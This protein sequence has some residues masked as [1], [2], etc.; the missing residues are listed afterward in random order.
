MINFFYNKPLLRLVEFLLF[1]CL[2][3]AG[4]LYLNASFSKL[5]T[6]GLLDAI[7][8][9][10]FIVAGFLF[11]LISEVADSYYFRALSSLVTLVGMF[12][13][14]YFIFTI[15][16]PHLDPGFMS[17]SLIAF[18][19]GMAF[20]LAF[21]IIVLGRLVAEKIRTSLVARI[22]ETEAKP[23]IS[24]PAEP[25]KVRAEAESLDSV[26]GAEEPAPVSTLSPA[27]ELGIGSILTCVGGPHLGEDYRLKDGENTIGRTEG[28]ILLAKD[29]QVSRR[30]AIIT[31]FQG[32]ITVTDLGSTNGTWVNGVRVTES[33]FKPGDV[34]SLGQSRFTVKQEKFQN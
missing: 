17:V 3:V 34:L 25:A 12:I 6:Q 32:R 24:M 23:P 33:P 9:Y 20:A 5:G 7:A 13:A 1:V 15:D 28:D 10:S 21:L 27:K 31:L 19:L 22:V 11:I 18:I 8:I 2:A 26:F 16:A 4:Y 14:F 30:H 29:P